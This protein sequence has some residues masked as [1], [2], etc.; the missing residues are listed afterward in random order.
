MA[1]ENILIIGPAWIGDMIMSQALYKLL[2]QQDPDVQIDVM[3]PGWSLPIVARMPEVRQGLELPMGH[4]Q[5][6]LRSRWRLGRSFRGKYDRVI[7]LPRTFKTAFIAW[8]TGAK[9]RVGFKGELRSWMLTFSFKRP[10]VSTAERYLSLANGRVPASIPVP[11]LV[12]DPAAGQALLQDLSASKNKSY[13]AVAPGAEFG[14][15]KRWPVRH[16]AALVDLLAAKGI[17]VV[18][19]GS[20]ADSE[21]G[22]ELAAL[23]KS[24]VLNA[25]GKTTLANV[26]DLISACAG[27]VANDSGLMHMSAAIGLPLV[28]VYGSTSP[29][30]AFPLSE[31]SAIEILDLECMPCAARHCPLEH[32]NCM[33]QL[34]PQQIFDRLMSLMA[35]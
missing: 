10:D 25:C 26:V 20:A 9:H 11:L 2:K 21:V 19:L 22:E 28:A 14:T 6:S 32:H 15:A 34:P 18:V 30:L 24:P 7:V 27:V 33:E 31:K 1:S 16:Y 35:D 3:G 4:G 29:K 8:A 12:T 23:A 13:I 5:F 17:G